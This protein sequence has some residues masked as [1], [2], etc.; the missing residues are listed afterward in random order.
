M[1]KATASYLLYPL[2]ERQQN[3][4]I[5]PK[6]KA[7]KAFSA[8]PRTAQQALVQQQLY[9]VV[10][11]AGR[12]VPYY[13]DLFQ[14]QQFDPEKLK[15]DISYLQE[16]PYLTKDILREQG[17]RLLSQK[18]E[19]AA[20]HVR[21]TGG[22]TG[23]SILIYYDQSALDWTAAANLH[24]L[25]WTGKKRYTKEAHFSS[26]FSEAIPTKDKLK[27]SIKCIALNR[28]NITTDTFDTETL[29]QA[30]HVLRRERPF[31]VQG[32]PST[33]Y[34]LA[35][36]K[37]ECDRHSNHTNAKSLFQAFESTGEVLSQK[38]FDTIQKIFKCK[39]YDRYGNAE[40][41]VVAH[42]QPYDKAH[43]EIQKETTNHRR[44]EVLTRI[45]WPETRNTQAGNQELVFTGLTNHAM[46][47]IRYCTGDIG[48]LYQDGNNLFIDQ[49]VG[50][51]HDLVNIGDH[52]YPTHYIQDFLD[53]L[54]GIDEFQLEQIDTKTLKIKLVMLPEESLERISSQ[55][56]NKWAPYVRIESIDTHELKTQGW[57]SKFRHLVTSEN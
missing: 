49:I 50:R 24:V 26:Y 38:Q 45:A 48:N 43:T 9:E 5:T 39:I 4:Q 53:R 52:I 30:L 47:L 16:L 54:G 41:G 2:L 42:T 33:L 28:V 17:E 12:D 34:R 19:R 23:P 25:E 29:Q 46:P 32:H 57:R 1:L 18:V 44:L 7:L 20:L 11:A 36:V 15:T 6:L 13:Q 40:F 10:A 35:V 51:I 27:E 37:E 22:S 56:I 21:K 31:I 3:R 55:I 8:L 14:Q